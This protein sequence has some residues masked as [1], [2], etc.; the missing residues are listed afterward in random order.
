MAEVRRGVHLFLASRHLQSGD[1][2]VELRDGFFDA[3]F[4]AFDGNDTA[5]SVTRLR[6]WVAPSDRV[7]PTDRPPC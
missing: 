4:Q 2:Q 6:R 1:P 5:A 3:L 7:R